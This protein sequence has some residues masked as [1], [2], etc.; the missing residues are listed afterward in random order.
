MPYNYGK[1]RDL[2]ITKVGRAWITI[3][4]GGSQYRFDPDTGGVDGGRYG[5]PGRVYA[6]RELYEQEVAV[7]AAWA[8]LLR[9]VDTA[10]R[11]VRSSE[12]FA[13]PLEDIAQARKLLKLDK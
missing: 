3:A 7:R 13:V 9:D 12:P 1:A 2:E 5:S 10:W 11:S 8:K 4:G 6:T